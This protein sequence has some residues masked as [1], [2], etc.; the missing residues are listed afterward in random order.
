M[1]WI[2]ARPSAFD[3]VNVVFPACPLPVLGC[4]VTTIACP[5]PSK[6]VLFP[7]AN[8]P[9]FSGLSG[10]LPF[11]TAIEPWG[12]NPLTPTIFI[13]EPFGA[14]AEGHFFVAV[15][16][17]F[18]G[19]LAKTMRFFVLLCSILEPIARM[20]LPE[21]VWLWLYAQCTDHESEGLAKGLGRGALVV[22]GVVW[23]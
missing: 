15:W 1:L 7:G 22:R 11:S 6:L 21:W 2:K 10:V 19:C 20:F 14:F 3:C 23:G 8:I 4:P 17:G 12:S 18:G 13:F 16:R 9:E 5:L